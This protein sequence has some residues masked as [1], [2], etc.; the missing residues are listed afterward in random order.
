MVVPLPHDRRRPLPPPLRIGIYT[1]TAASTSASASGLASASAVVMVATPPCSSTSSM[2]VAPGRAARQ[3]AG[4][5]A[6]VGFDYYQVGVQTAEY[7]VAILGGKKPSELPARVAEGTDIV[8]NPAV[9]KKLGITL[10]KVLT[11]NPSRIVK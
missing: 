9:A 6:A 8:I 5:V 1:G 4:A 10:P 3:V 2:A 7:I 11:E